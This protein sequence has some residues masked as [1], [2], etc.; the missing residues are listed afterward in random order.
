MFSIK[1]CFIPCDR[2]AGMDM[3]ERHAQCVWAAGG[4]GVTREGVNHRADGGVCVCVGVGGGGARFARK[5]GVG[6]AAEGEG[7]GWGCR[8]EGRSGRGFGAGS[9]WDSFAWC[10][11]ADL[12]GV[13]TYML[14]FTSAAAGGVSDAMLLLLL[15]VSLLLPPTHPPTPNPPGAPVPVWSV[16]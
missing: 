13:Y 11:V 8:S 3:Q 10:H 2:Q 9:G 14:C 4:G 12:S 15:L 1:H 16:V 7:V 5:V 6:A